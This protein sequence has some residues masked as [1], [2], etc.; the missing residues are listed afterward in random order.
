MSRSHQ[1]LDLDRRRLFYVSLT[2][3]K[4]ACIVSHA[5]Q[6]SGAPAFRLGGSVVRLPR[7]QFLNEMAVPSMNRW[8]GMTTAEATAIVADMRNL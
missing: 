5:G 1:P 8:T 2:R 6:H 4:A 7:C 3:A